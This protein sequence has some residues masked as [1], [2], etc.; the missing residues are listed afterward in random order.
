M[1]FKAC[2]K[3]KA[4]TAIHVQVAYE[5]CW[6][7]AYI[8]FFLYNLQCKEVSA[9]PRYHSHMQRRKLRIQS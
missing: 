5:L 9:H 3:V 8:F 4:M 1:V 6:L 2:F 7:S